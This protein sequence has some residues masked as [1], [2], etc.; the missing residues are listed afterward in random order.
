MFIKKPDSIVVVRNKTEKVS[1]ECT[2]D[3][4][5]KAE[6]RWVKN[7]DQMIHIG[8]ELNLNE[9]FDGE[10]ECQ[11]HYETFSPISSKVSLITE[12]PPLFIGKDTFYISSNNELDIY[13][14]VLSSP[15]YNVCSAV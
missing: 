6:I 4:N 2:V 10:Y 12:G 1:L 13:F 7:F 11:A 9:N 8:E 14:N 15:S 5:P 3:S